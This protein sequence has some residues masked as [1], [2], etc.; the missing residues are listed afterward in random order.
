V[1][2]S[3]LVSISIVA[4]SFY[5]FIMR[6]E[7][8]ITNVSESFVEEK[9]EAM[10]S[11]LNATLSG[12][13]ILLESSTRLFE[14]CKPDSLTSVKN[15]VKLTKNIGNF[16]AVAVA[17]TYGEA[18][19]CYG[20]L[21]GNVEEERFF[22]E[23]MEGKVF[24]SDLMRFSAYSEEVMIISMPIV[25]NETCV[26][27]LFG[28]FDRNMLS[29]IIKASGEIATGVSFLMTKEGSVLASSDPA[30]F[31][32]VPDKEYFSLRGSW[33]TRGGAVHYADDNIFNRDE[34]VSYRY[35][36]D[37]DAKYAIITPVGDYNWVLAVVLPNEALNSSLRKI[38]GFMAIL[39]A[40]IA[41][42]ATIV[43]IS[44]ILL[45]RSDSAVVK[46][47]EKYRLASQHNKAIIFEY[48]ASKARLELSGDTGLLLGN[49][50]LTYTGDEITGILNKIHAD[51]N[52]FRESFRSL[53]AHSESG[54]NTEARLLCSDNVHRW[55]KIRSVVN[56]G[57]DGKIRGIVGSIT[58]AEAE[59]GNE[60]VLKFKDSN[61]QLTGVFNRESFEA[62]AER[63]L[64]E[65]SG[66]SL[67]ALYLIDIDNFKNINDTF[68]HVIGDKIIGEVAKK[69]GL[70]FSEKDCIG[71][72]GGD[73]FAVLLLLSPDSIK[74]G[75]R[76][77][78]DKA[79]RLCKEAD[80]I[81]SD[82]MKSVR[83]TL[84][85]GV[86]CFPQDGINYGE[87]RRRADAAL[88][89]AK[90]SGKNQSCIYHEEGA[91]DSLVL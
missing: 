28:I 57:T 91:G 88:Y 61:D 25:K 7:A 38:A 52:A 69:I 66:G 6:T 30:V 87:L 47:N 60:D 46:S 49:A 21:L 22:R 51:D 83:V 13:E 78:A 84:S 26:A 63:E 48:D 58:N 72:V 4:L 90:H 67:Y 86:S 74:T 18:V 40:G 12:H 16:K 36:I 39:M 19:D 77:V 31:S 2:V 54:M 59:S 5:L 9:A 8:T 43:L 3:G 27:V 11:A 81:Y 10:A 82:G 62:R 73:G 76:I 24:V 53:D 55:F 14:S 80:G 79:S 70:I 20:N 64:S 68:G 33:K 65:A 15:I 56:F 32:K 75:L 89:A 85:V 29:D 34:T 41:I 23:S 35:D 45:M 44:V 50:P 17:T 42:A 37:G 71:R 1:I